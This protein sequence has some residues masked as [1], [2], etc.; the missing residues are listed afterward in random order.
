MFFALEYGIEAGEI[1]P[2]V[3]DA[4][5]ARRPA[6]HGKP[7]SAMVRAFRLGQGLILDRLLEELPGTCVA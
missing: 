5:R 3:A 7:V 4:E 6:R 2:P 1:Q